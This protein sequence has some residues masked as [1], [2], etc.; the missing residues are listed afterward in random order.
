MLSTPIA[1]APLKNLF[2]IYKKVCKGKTFGINY[3]CFNGRRH[4]KD[5]EWPAMSREEKV[6]VEGLEPPCLAAPDPKSGTSTNFATPAVGNTSIL[7]I[8]SF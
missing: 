2:S 4:R 7:K 6:R 1:P 5:G 8:L 3:Y